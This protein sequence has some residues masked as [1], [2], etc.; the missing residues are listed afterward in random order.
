MLSVPATPEGWSRF[1]DWVQHPVLMTDPSLSDEAERNAKRDFILDQLE[2]WS[3]SYSKAEVVAEAQA[4][5]LPAS[6]VA[7]P[8]E[9]AEDPQLVARGFLTEVEHPEFDR[10]LFPAGAIATVKGTRVGLAP[11]LGQHNA[12]ILAELG[13]SE[14]D[15]Q[16]LIESGAI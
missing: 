2:E 10:L 7:T 15:H 6:P 12:E 4:R 8:L 13:Y 16:A 3:K 1:I 11:R 5:R 14:A 9:L